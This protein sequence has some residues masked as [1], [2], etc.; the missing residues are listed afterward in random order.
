MEICECQSCDIPAQ[1]QHRISNFTDEILE[2]IEETRSQCNETEVSKLDLVEI[3]PDK[4]CKVLSRNKITSEVMPSKAV[5]TERGLPHPIWI[6]TD[7]E[8]KKLNVTSKIIIKESASNT[9]INELL[10]KVN[11]KASFI[12]LKLERD[13]GPRFL[14]D[15]R[16]LPF[17]D[18]IPI[19]LFTRYLRR[20]S[21]DFEKVY[22]SD[23]D[24]I[25]VPAKT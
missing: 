25:L 19:R 12:M 16:D 7:Y 22:A 21:S 5:R 24:N 10:E 15:G 11:G 13:T 3:S 20:F 6:D 23:S 17:N 2:I 4:I 1:I 14:T 9:D 8:N 18:A